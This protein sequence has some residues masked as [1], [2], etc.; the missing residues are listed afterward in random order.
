[1]KGEAYD[2]LYEIINPV[3]PP[4]LVGEPGAERAADAIYAMN[5]TRYRQ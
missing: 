3:E 5:G 4:R 2:I 1:M